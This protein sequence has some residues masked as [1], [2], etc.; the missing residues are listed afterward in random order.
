MERSH[1]ESFADVRIVLCIGGIAT[2]IFYTPVNSTKG[3][4]SEQQ[5]TQL[6][7]VR[8]EIRKQLQSHQNMH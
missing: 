3:V 2:E 5:L 1:E 8:A 7:K 6:M 4:L